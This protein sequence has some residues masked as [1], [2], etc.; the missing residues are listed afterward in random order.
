MPGDTR[1]LKDARL[2]RRFDK[3]ASSSVE[4]EPRVASAH[5]WLFILALPDRHVLRPLETHSLQLG[6]LR[7]VLGRLRQAPDRS[8]P[9]SA[10]I[11]QLTERS[12]LVAAFGPPACAA[13]RDATGNGPFDITTAN[14]GPPPLHRRTNAASGDYAMPWAASIR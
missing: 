1:W 12:L 9:C 10:V 7:C 13:F 5:L 8:A 2:P 14:P 6:S 4:L 11:P 3:S